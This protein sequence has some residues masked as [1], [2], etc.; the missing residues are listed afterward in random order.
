MKDTRKCKLIFLWVFLFI[1]ARTLFAGENTEESNK[2]RVLAIEEFIELSTKNDT[3]FEAILID[4]LF[5]QYSKDLKLPARDLVLSVKG[6]Y[7]FFL[8]QNREDPGSTVSLDKLFPYSG[9]NLSASYKSIPSFSSRTN[10]SEFIFSVSQPIAKNAFGKT[11]RLQDKIIGLEIDV[12]KYQIIEAYEDYFA[13]I[14]NVYYAWYEAYENLK[15]GESSYAENFKLFKN[16][17]ERQSS[18]I[19]LPIDV[20][21]INIQVLAKKEKLVNL[22][23]EYDRA[24]NIVEKTIRYK[25][26]E[27]LKPREP[28]SYK[29]KDINF[30]KDYQSFREDSRTYRILNLLENKSLLEVDKNA[31]DLLPS[32]KLLLGYEIDGDDFEIKDEKNKIYAGVSVDWP[33]PDQVENAE[34]KTAKIVLDKTRLTQKNTYFQLYT[35][36]EN[37][38]RQIEKEKELISISDEKIKLAEAVVIDETENYSFGKVTLND[39]I[40]AVNLLD[41]NRFNKIS[42]SIRLKKLVVE[43]LRLTDRLIDKKDINI[44]E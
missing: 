1:I 3:V 29:G 16:V 20:N 9:T 41:D 6:Q 24:L 35:D 15:I 4:E 5:L 34:Y 7:D 12:A 14:I 13:L 10:S 11:T 32:I 21:K 8:S 40:Q 37:L 39:F 30:E 36:L 23:Q 25:G 44:N 17:Q 27:I 31:G 22:K 42:Y 43:W 28:L 33:F 19:A 2:S 26:D 38:Y 18:R